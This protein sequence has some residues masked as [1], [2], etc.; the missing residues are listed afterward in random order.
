MSDYPFEMTRFGRLPWKGLGLLAILV[1]GVVLLATRDG[2]AEPAWRS[3]LEAAGAEARARGVPLL[4]DFWAGW[5]K[6]CMYL[7]IMLFEDRAVAEEIA[8][9]YVPVRVDLTLDP[10]PG[11]AVEAAHRY[12]VESLPTVL[13]VDPE[14]GAPIARADEKDTASVKAFTDFL[15]RHAGH[16]H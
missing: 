12:E 8:A 2:G 14:T 10:P 9:H 3:D 16:A 4:V 1:A 11:D 6:P 5:C 15:H 13:V 7:D